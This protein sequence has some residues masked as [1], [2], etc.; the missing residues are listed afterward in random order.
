M[1]DLYILTGANGAGKSTVGYSYLPAAVQKK[2][3]I[4][5]GDKLTL[6]KKREFYLSGIKFLP[7]NVSAKPWVKPGR[8]GIQKRRYE[9]AYPHGQ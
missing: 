4:F 9:L 2:Y 3:T 1:P 7:S 6:Q 8:C 5:D